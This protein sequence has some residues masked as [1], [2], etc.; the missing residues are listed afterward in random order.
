M[1]ETEFAALHRRAEPLLLPNAWDHASAALLADAGFRAVAT[2][3]LGVAAAAGRPDGARTTR[4]ETLRV[5]KIL[6]ADRRY[7]LSID[8]EDGYSDDPAE[9]AAYARELAAA[10]AVGLNLEDGRPDGTLTDPALHAAKIAAVKTA[11]P[12]LFVNARTDTHWLDRRRE[13]TLPRLTAY[14]D[15]GADGVFVPGISDP[16]EISELVKAIALPLNVLYRPGGLSITELGD[17]GVRR[18]SLG[19]LLYRVALGA[20][21]HV[22]GEIA[23]GRPAGPAELHAPSYA[24]VQQLS[25]PP[26][27]GSDV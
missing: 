10:G 14:R 4:D 27:S 1:S 3:S 6:G 26:D 16:A 9:V 12:E 25:A 2:T 7:L 20:A 13:E 24:D 21:L 11:V 23:E 17:I 19:S 5:A 18:I 15:A 8:A 22:A